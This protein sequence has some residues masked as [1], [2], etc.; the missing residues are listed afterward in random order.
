M[1]FL[2]HAGLALS[3]GLGA[4]DQR[5]LAVRRPAARRLR[6]GRAPGWGRLRAARRAS[7]R[8][9]WAALLAVAA[10]AIDW[11]G[12]AGREACASA[13]WPPAWAARRPS[14]SA[15][16]SRR[17]AAARFL[18]PRLRLRHAAQRP[19]RGS[20]LG[21][22]RAPCRFHAPTALE[23]FASLVADDASLPLLE[24]A[25]AIAQDD[26]PGARHARP[27]WPRSTRLAARLKRRIA[28]RR[29][30]DAAAAP[31]E[32]LLLPG[33]RLRRQ[34]QR[35][36]RPAQ[37]LPALRARR[38]RRGIPITLAL[39][40]VEL[41][42]Q[43][44]LHAQRRLVPRP[45]PGQAAHAAGRGRDRSVH[46]PVDVARGARRA[47]RALPARRGP[48]GRLRRCRSALF[49]QAAPPREVHRAHAAQPEGDPPQRRGLAAPARRCRS[50]S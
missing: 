14:T 45:L 40:Y 5:G 1:P 34:R 41:A 30:A 48:A 4:L 10:R 29:R 23:Y 16:C 33:A 19:A 50:A 46:R 38:R 7:R 17:A 2:G 3:V 32:P 27:C 42:T 6:T 49:L 36:L 25:L 18:A 35:L 31:A 13:G 9:C 24:A 28:G 22:C 15:S 11:I 37:Q 21:R 44:G 39:L 26:Y 8:C 47:A 43:V 20:K 12:L